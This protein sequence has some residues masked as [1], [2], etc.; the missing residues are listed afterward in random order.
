MT[1][2]R[3]GPSAVTD[4]LGRTGRLVISAAAI[5]MLSFLSMSSAG[6]LG[7]PPPG[8]LTLA[9]ASVSGIA[10]NGGHA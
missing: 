4:G 8:P 9:P 6:P 7:T 10:Q 1:S 2:I 3:D 5:L